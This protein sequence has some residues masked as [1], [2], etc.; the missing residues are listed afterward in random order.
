MITKIEVV[1]AILI[2]FIIGSII[3]YG[4]RAE[5]D[6]EARYGIVTGKQIGRAHV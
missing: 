6:C 5:A 4:V 1:L 3:Y 2:T